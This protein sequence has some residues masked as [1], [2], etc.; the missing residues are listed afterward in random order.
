MKK[1]QTHN[2]RIV[3]NNPQW[4]QSGANLPAT[5]QHQ[6][7]A[8]NEHDQR[9]ANIRENNDFYVGGTSAMKVVGLKLVE[10]DSQAS[11]FY[12]T[13]YPDYGVPEEYLLNRLYFESAEPHHGGGYYLYA[14]NNPHE[15]TAA[16]WQNLLINR[17]ARRDT[18]WF[19]ILRCEGY[20]PFVAYDARGK[21]IPY[22]QWNQTKKLACSRLIPIEFLGHWQA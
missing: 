17:F 18:S 11:R 7:I 14:T 1:V 13:Y 2:G 12:S 3:I 15:L 21:C 20:G 16:F 6:T 22:G 8:P 4:Y 10:T 9:I 5:Y 19:G